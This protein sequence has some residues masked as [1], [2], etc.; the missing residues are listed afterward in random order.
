M[1]RVLHL[2]MEP[3]MSILVL[4]LLALL[5]VYAQSC[6]WSTSSSNPLAS[7]PENSQISY[8]VLPSSLNDEAYLA[9]I[10]TFKPDTVSTKAI[11]MASYSTMNEFPSFI[12]LYTLLTHLYDFLKKLFLKK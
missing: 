12:G 10:T 11:R 6:S 4:L 7:Y 3:H 5:G 1:V 9:C 2:Y 8:R